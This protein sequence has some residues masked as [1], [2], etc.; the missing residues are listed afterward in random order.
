MPRGIR[1]P[2]SAVERVEEAKLME[3]EVPAAQ[4]GGEG[5]P[6]VMGRTEYDFLRNEM[7]FFRFEI[8]DVRWED[9]EDTFLANQHIDRLEKRIDGFEKH[10]DTQEGMLKAI[11]DRL[12][13]IVGA[14]SS[15]P[16]GVQQ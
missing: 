7:S 9:R 3:E 8:A 2:I 4:Q 15:T 5:E 14:S 11:L 6:I 16:Y 12:P 1:V 10:F 13:P